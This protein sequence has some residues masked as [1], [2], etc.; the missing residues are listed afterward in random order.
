MVGLLYVYITSQEWT[1]ILDTYY[2]LLT[3]NVF[4]K[5]YSYTVVPFGFNH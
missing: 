5:V 3:Y 4:C 2:I 1:K